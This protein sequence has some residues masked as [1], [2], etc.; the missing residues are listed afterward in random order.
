MKKLIKI[1]IL[2]VLVMVSGCAIQKKE[3][4]AKV[5]DTSMFLYKVSNQ[6]GEYSYLFGTC[7]PGRYPIKSLD[8]VT[9]K[10]LDESDSI[11]LECSLDQKE[12]QKYSKYLPYYSIRQ[13]GLED[14]Y[15]D[16]M[17]Q[18]KSLEGKSDYVTYNAFAISSIAGSDLEVLNKVNISKYNAIDNYIYDY[19]QKKKNFK[20]VEGVEF[21]MKLF[22]KLSKSHSQEILTELKNKKEFING[23]KKIID[24]YYSGNTQYYEDEQ[25]LILDY[26]EHMQDTE[27]VRNYLNVL[28]Y[29]R[30][31]H[32]KDTLINS[33]NNGK[34]DFIGVG[35]R[36]LYGRKGI[37]QL[38]R[39]DGYLVECM[40]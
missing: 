35:V 34:H 1:I 7:H 30:N 32:M 40:K 14:L 23:S 28:Y 2:V 26:F 4:N 39:D 9:E 29:N 15:E 27:K 12:L 16:V 17:K 20:E 31:I 21:Q 19:A 6:E 22:A 18:Y 13:L 8:K 38:L 24:A 10:A 5:I 25:N 3:E 36:H 33:I 11:Y 37:I